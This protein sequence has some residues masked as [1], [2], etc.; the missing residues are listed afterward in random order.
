MNGKRLVFKVLA[1]VLAL[2]LLAATGFVIWA[3][4]PLGPMPEALAALE[5]DDTVRVETEPW[6]I[7]QPQAQMPTSGVILYP[8]GRVDARSYAPAARALAEKGF[9]AV[10]TPMPLN[11]AVFAAGVV[12]AYPEI[13]TWII[14]GHSLG[15]AMAA[16]YAEANA[17]VID[18]LALWASYPANDNLATR[19]E[20]A[21][22][23]I[24]ATNDGVSTME[25]IAASRADLP[26]ATR[27]V[28]IAGG[29]HAQ[30]GWYG[31]QP[32]DGT[33]TITR[34]QQQEQVVSATAEF[35]EILARETSGR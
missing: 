4:T 14:G 28:E 27:W 1:I 31:E 26:A 13:T 2:T 10:I 6:L 17:D 25:D 8:G 34:E 12:T 9:L 22:I 16:S 32:G 20:P 3:Q 33:A 11:L 7:F 24:Y 23:S 21:V 5:T 29:N 18:G 19:Q 35:L 15:G 30:F